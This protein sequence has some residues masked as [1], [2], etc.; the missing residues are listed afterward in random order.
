[1]HQILLEDGELVVS[2]TILK[3]RGTTL[4]EIYIKSV[5]EEKLLYTYF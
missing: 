1:M 3:F 2:Y 4:R 5:R